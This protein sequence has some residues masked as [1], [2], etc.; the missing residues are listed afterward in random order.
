[1]LIVA[2][3]AFP[4]LFS[5]PDCCQSDLPKLKLREMN[6]HLNK[7]PAWLTSAQWIQSHSQHGVR[8]STTRLQPLASSAFSLPSRAP[9]SPAIPHSSITGLTRARPLLPSASVMLFSSP[10]YTKYSRSLSRVN[11]FLS[12]TFPGDSF[13]YPS[14]NSGRTFIRALATCYCTE[15]LPRLSPA[16]TPRTPYWQG[17]RIIHPCVPRS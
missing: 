16:S 2:Q 14:W 8:T 12:E 13:L 17:P 5:P 11:H 15:L 9:L 10:V 4:S 1:M 3:L 6:L 7:K